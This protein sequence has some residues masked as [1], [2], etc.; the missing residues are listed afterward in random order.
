MARFFAVVIACVAIS[1]AGA[2]ETCTRGEIAPT[3]GICQGTTLNMRRC[4]KDGFLIYPGYIEYMMYPEYILENEKRVYEGYTNPWSVTP[5]GVA[6]TSCPATIAA[7]CAAANVT[8][9]NGTDACGM[10]CNGLADCTT[11][12]DCPTEQP[13]TFVYRECCSICETAHAAG[14]NG[15]ETGRAG[16]TQAEVTAAISA[17]SAPASKRDGMFFLPLQQTRVAL[18]VCVRV[19]ACVCVC[20]CVC[21]CLCVC[22]C[23]CLRVC[24]SVCVCAC[25]CVC[26][27]ACVRVRASLY[28]LSAGPGSGAGGR[29]RGRERGGGEFPEAPEHHARLTGVPRS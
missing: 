17:V 7:G 6:E 16:L 27:C 22:V 10:V 3:A 13:I 15:P 9:K 1:S 11:D 14:C 24:V 12:A 20:V 28:A 18:C 21:V 29:E 2:A 8:A 26:V 23:V 25:V 19:F 4:T 5:P